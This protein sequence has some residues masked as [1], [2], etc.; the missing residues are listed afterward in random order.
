LLYYF[1]MK[2]SMTLRLTLILTFLVSLIGAYFLLFSPEVIEKIYPQPIVLDIAHTQLAM[3]IGIFLIVFAAAALLGL[4]NP[5]KNA[6]AIFI[7]ILMHF[8]AFVTDVVLLAQGTELPLRY[9]IPD[10]TYVLII[11][12]LLIRYYPTEP[13]A[14]DM[15]KTA[16]QLVGAVQKQLKKEAKSVKQEVPQQKSESMFSKLKSKFNLKSK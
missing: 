4:V 10:M 6:S 3:V 8:A 7:L 1:G 16:D 13:T 2:P 9:L 15:T 11:C 14:V 12:I 5:I